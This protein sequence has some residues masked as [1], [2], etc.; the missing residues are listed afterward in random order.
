MSDEL[1]ETLLQLKCNDEKYMFDIV[2][3][4]KVATPA[5][6]TDAPIA[7]EATDAAAATPSTSST[8]NPRE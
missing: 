7:T 3:G 5:P 6:A 2:K 1:F 8:L 4:E